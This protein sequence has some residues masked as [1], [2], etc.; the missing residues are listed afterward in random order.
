LLFVCGSCCGGLKGGS[1]EEGAEGSVYPGG[2]AFLESM[3]LDTIQTR[4][5]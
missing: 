2:A 5:M 4:P 3:L 1:K